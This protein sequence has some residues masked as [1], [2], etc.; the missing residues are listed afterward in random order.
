MDTILDVDLSDVDGPKYLALAEAIRSAIRAGRLAP[1][2]KMPPVRDLAWQMKVTPGTVARAYQRLT[3]AGKLRA[4]VGRGTF[5]AEAEATPPAV[6]PVEIRPLPILSDPDVLD[7]RS[8]VLPDVGQGD[9]IRRAL[10]QVAD[11]PTDCFLD[12]PTPSGDL[13]VRGLVLRKIESFD[14]ACLTPE[15]VVLTH[16]GQHALSLIFQVALSGARPV[17]LTEELSYSGFRHAARLARATVIAIEQD[18][19]GPVPASVRAAC[20]RH[21]VQV[22]ATS[23]HAHNPTTI[24]TSPARRQQ[25]AALAR[26][27]DFQIIDDQS[28]S[29]VRRD[30]PSYR[31]LVPERVWYVSSV[32]K[33]V[34]PGLRMGWFIAPDGKA[35]IG[36]LAARHSFFGLSRPILEVAADVLGA[37]DA[38]ELRQRVVDETAARVAILRAAL[39][40]YALRSRSDVAFAY[41]P[42][43]LGWRASSFQRACERK[44]ILIR[45]AD[46][47]VLQN[48]RAP[49]AVRFG[50]NG[51]VPRAE[52][53]RGCQAL[54]RLLDA[55]PHEMGV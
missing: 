49:N 42:L 4:H 10:H 30:R 41:L 24:T 51:R 28:Y 11:L 55:P 44:G 46:E 34:A 8:P 9:Q 5:V 32:S 2:D 23:G 12:Y 21:E 31:D 53:E 27:F 33:S 38:A 43:P 37:P 52:F 48:G 54:R 14:A 40:G 39:D 20:E 35:E 18:E 3:D 15:H 26:E 50:I 25:I 1:G 6:L 36:Q 7:L 17:V 45:S 47:Y 22:L 13:A 19:E 16:G 29:L